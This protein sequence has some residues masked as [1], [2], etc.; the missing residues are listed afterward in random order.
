VTAGNAGAPATVRLPH[1]SET[2]FKG[3]L[4][5]V[6]T[7]KVCKL[8]NFHIFLPGLLNIY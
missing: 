6:Y 1:Y 7:G 5:Y 8:T 4:V 2:N 3:F